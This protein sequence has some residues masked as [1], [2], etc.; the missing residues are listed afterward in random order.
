[1]LLL[2]YCAPNRLFILQNISIARR[3]WDNG[4]LQSVRRIKL[5]AINGAPG[6][7]AERVTVHTAVQ[8]PARAGAPTA[9]C[10]CLFQGPKSACVSSK[11][12][13]EAGRQSSPGDHARGSP[14]PMATE[15]CCF[16]KPIVGD[17]FHVSCPF[18]FPR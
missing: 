2:Y 14:A 3:V 18:L 4:L 16:F 13:R 9:S 12:G 6:R 1:M 7:Q 5:L 17:S 11:R 10:I 8:G 15:R